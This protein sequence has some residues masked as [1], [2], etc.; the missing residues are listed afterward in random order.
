MSDANILLPRHVSYAEED[1]RHFLD[2]SAN[3]EDDTEAAVRHADQRDFDMPAILA[4]HEH[5]LNSPAPY[6]IPEHL[7]VGPHRA[8]SLAPIAPTAHHTPLPP[9][10]SVSLPTPAFQHTPVLQHGARTPLFVPLTPERVLQDFEYEYPQQP[11]ASRARTLLFL[12]GTLRREPTPP[13]LARDDVSMSDTPTL[14]LSRHPSPEPPQKRRH[15]DEQALAR[16]HRVSALLDLHADDNNDEDNA[17]NT[18]SDEDLTLNMSD[19][20]FIDDEEE[21]PLEPA[22]PLPLP[23][24][25]EDIGQLVDIAARF[26]QE[27]D[28]Y[29]E[30]ALL[31]DAP[32]PEVS[33]AASVLAN[34]TIVGRAV[35]DTAHSI[36]P[37]PVPLHA[38]LP[39]TATAAQIAYR[40]HRLLKSDNPG[41]VEPGTWIYLKEEHAGRLAFAISSKE[42][43]VARKSRDNFIDDADEPEVNDGCEIM[44]FRRHLNKKAHPRV[45][46][47]IDDVEPFQRSR[48]PMFTTADFVGHSQALQLCDRVKVWRGV[49]AGTVGYILDVKRSNPPGIKRVS[50]MKVAPVLP[51]ASADGQI[52][53]DWFQLGELRRHVLPPSPR[54]HLLDRVCVIGNRMAM[55]MMEGYVM[56]IADTED[57]AGMVTV[58]DVLGGRCNVP[59][60]SVERA[61]RARDTVIVRRGKYKGRAGIVLAHFFTVLEVFDGDAHMLDGVPIVQQEAMTE[62]HTFRVHLVDVDLV[63]YRDSD[64]NPEYFPAQSSISVV[65]HPDVPHSKAIYAVGRRYEGLHVLVVGAGIGASVRTGRKTGISSSSPFKGRRGLVIADYDSPQH[66]R[67]LSTKPAGQRRG[68]M[69]RDTCGIMVTIKDTTNHQINVD[70]DFVVHEGTGLPLAQILHLPRELLTSFKL[71]T[72]VE[73]PPR[74]RTPNP[75]AGTNETVDW[76]LPD[77]YE[78]FRLPGESDGQW[79]CIAVLVGKRVDVLVEG[80]KKMVRTKYHKPSPLLFGLDERHGFLLIDEPITPEA[81]VQAK[82]MV[83]TV[84]ANDRKHDVPG[85]FLKQVWDSP[86]GTLITGLRQ[87][88]MII[89]G[90]MAGDTSALG[91]YVETRPDIAHSHGQHVFAVMLKG[92]ASPFFFYILRLGCAT[93]K[94]AENEKRKFPSTTFV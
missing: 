82:I 49:H 53:G 84:D 58:E 74:P 41:E 15:L 44:M 63:V 6:R 1:P 52:P 32:A 79:L 38:P 36:L 5:R 7:L 3:Q 43:I 20:E 62:C 29:A 17:G 50:M 45:Y 78:S 24:E 64:S 90:D 14:S 16:H 51:L 33:A 83:Y 39:Q 81:L 48:H 19:L 2:D 35:Q 76:G 8:D 88:V 55:A 71:A 47:T 31:E 59:M 70:I 54:L 93:N 28:A 34:S 60:G 13:I 92:G 40:V 65:A 10:N 68:Q 18:E 30:S 85:Q 57:Y 25:Q 77:R 46:P 94:E 23:R 42:C 72:A 21:D 11:S 4:G 87:R 27:A 91:S 56:D 67:R 37:R 80:I 61:F 12:P 89:G 69:R 22:P 9:L 86:D 66:V 26:E 73:L 75:P